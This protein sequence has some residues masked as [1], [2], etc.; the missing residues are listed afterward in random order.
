[1]QNYADAK[2]LLYPASAIR[3]RLANGF[4][5]ADQL[6]DF[7]GSGWSDALGI[8]PESFAALNPTVSIPWAQNPRNLGIENLHFARF[9]TDGTMSLGASSPKNGREG[10]GDD[11]AGFFVM[12]RAVALD[13]R[14]NAQGGSGDNTPINWAA[15][16]G[17]WQALP[18]LSPDAGSAIYT[19]GSEVKHQARTRGVIPKN[20]GFRGTLDFLLKKSG[21]TELHPMVRLRWGDEW[22]LTFRH[23]LHPIVERALVTDKGDGVIELHWS[24]VKTLSSAPKTDM[25]GKSVTFDVFRLAGRMCIFI[26]GRGFWLLDTGFE[27][28]D[29]PSGVPI[30]QPD[31]TTQQ[32]KPKRPKASEVNWREAALGVESLNARV[33]VALSVIC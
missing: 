3:N 4:I 7:A 2:I 26:D 33:S 23:G 22:A 10:K 15:E 28:F 16:L 27:M 31:G 5:V 14:I 11:L 13:C 20:R 18:A 21:K 6:A 1:M 12:P 17:T 8:L 24:A 29:N 30:P 25:R 9:H 19:T 32:P